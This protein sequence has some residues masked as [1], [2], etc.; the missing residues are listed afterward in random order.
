[1]AADRSVCF[2]QATHHEQVLAFTAGGRRFGLGF[3]A[4]TA[5]PAVVFGVALT[6]AV[7]PV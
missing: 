7:T 4:G 1:M 2:D 3:L 5:V 6:A